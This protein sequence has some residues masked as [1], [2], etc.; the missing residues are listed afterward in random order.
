M[1]KSPDY[2]NQ[3]VPLDMFKDMYFKLNESPV[4]RGL[5]VKLNEKKYT[6]KDSD[7]SYRSINHWSSKNI[8]Q[9][10]R[11]KAG[12]RKF[13]LLDLI[14]LKAL[15]KLRDFGFSIEQ[16]KNL[17]DNVYK[18]GDKNHDHR[19]ETAISL[20]FRTSPVATYLMVYSTGMG[21][22]ATSETLPL[23]EGVV[24]KNF[25][26]IKI[27]LNS[28]YVELSGKEKFSATSDILSGLENL[29]IS[30][31]GHI[32]SEDYHE[33]VLKLENM[34]IKEFDVKKKIHAASK[35]TEELHNLGYGKIT[36]IL[37]NG[38]FQ[39]AEITKKIKT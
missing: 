11:E 12:W 33:V 34:K 18:I 9:E 31:Q 5:S 2:K 14:W 36:T 26:Y 30:L 10:D 35:I 17:S 13:S 23:I 1:T 27:D 19:F 8:I 24:G 7:V 15:Q 39:Y 4:W 3:Y 21:Q 20:S 6:V 25:P 32:K 38:H 28:V 16:L 37:E 29:E 22:L